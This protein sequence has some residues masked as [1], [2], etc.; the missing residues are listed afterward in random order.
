[1]IRED[2]RPGDDLKRFLG[3]AHFLKYL[4]RVRRVKLEMIMPGVVEEKE[5]DASSEDETPSEDSDGVTPVKLET[6]SPDNPEVLLPLR[7]AQKFQGK[8]KSA[9]APRK[10]LP[11]RAHRAP[12]SGL[13]SG[14]PQQHFRFLQFFLATNRQFCLD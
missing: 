5:G 13:K 3:F 10:A 7:K 11:G 12:R 8:G 9:A 6:D 4:L 2:E 1:M 14:F